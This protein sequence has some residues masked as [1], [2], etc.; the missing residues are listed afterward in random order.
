MCTGL[1]LKN[2]R[3]ILDYEKNIVLNDQVYFKVPYVNYVD[4][5]DK[6]LA[7]DL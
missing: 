5:K 3:F 4:S 1:D 2:T 6:L 7:N